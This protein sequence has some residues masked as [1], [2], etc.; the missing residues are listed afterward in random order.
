MPEAGIAWPAASCAMFFRPCDGRWPWRWIDKGAL[1][2]ASC[3]RY[4][5][6]KAP[7]TK[8]SMPDLGFQ[9]PELLSLT[10]FGATW[11]NISQKQKP[12]VTK[13]WIN[14][15]PKTYRIWRHLGVT[16]DI[17]SLDSPGPSAPSAALLGRSAGL[18]RRSA[19]SRP[20]MFGAARCQGG[21]VPVAFLS[22]WLK[23]VETMVF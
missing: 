20:P 14:N 1:G 18:H 19:G 10:H 22:F 2:I 9:P 4:I 3:C 21:A 13:V 23:D 12:H 15:H 6:K 17:H 8:S 5:K 7:S 11:K 16:Y